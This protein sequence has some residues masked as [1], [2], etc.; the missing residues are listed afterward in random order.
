MFVFLIYLNT[1]KSGMLT[2]ILN[3]HKIH[4]SFNMAVVSLCYIIYVVDI[5]IRSFAEG[6]KGGVRDYG[7]LF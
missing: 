3:L 4:A 2:V 7:L 5:G 1:I 6:I